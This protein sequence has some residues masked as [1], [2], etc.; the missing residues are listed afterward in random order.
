MKAGQGPA[1]ADSTDIASGGS[2]AVD[3]RSDS[4]DDF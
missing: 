4:Y 2:P 3:D 1:L